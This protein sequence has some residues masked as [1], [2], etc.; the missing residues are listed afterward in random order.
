VVVTHGAMTIIDAL[1]EGTPVIAVPRLKKYHEVINDHQIYLVQ[2]L[3]KDGKVTAVYDVEELEEALEK[4]G[5]KP[6]K[7]VKDRRLVDT[8]KGYIV[9]F[10]RS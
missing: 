4:V 7:L 10:E 9:R 1:E 5:T 6:V 3:E 8:L 2:E